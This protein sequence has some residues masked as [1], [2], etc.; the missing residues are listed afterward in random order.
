MS[1]FQALLGIGRESPVPQL[2][3]QEADDGEGQALLVIHLET[4]R[5]DARRFSGAA[6]PSQ[7][8]EGWGCPDRTLQLSPSQAHWLIL[9][10]R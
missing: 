9:S 5:D 1:T 8:H 6:D 3:V 10:A 4:G 7:E 2:V